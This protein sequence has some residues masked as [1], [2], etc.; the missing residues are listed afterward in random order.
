MQNWLKSNYLLAAL[1]DIKGADSGVSNTA[2]G[3]TTSHAGHI[4]ISVVNVSHFVSVDV[5]IVCFL[6]ELVLSK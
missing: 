6:L 3:D 2:C 1:D 4:V 5:D